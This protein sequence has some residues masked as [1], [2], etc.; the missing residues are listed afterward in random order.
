MNGI[1]VVA[2]VPQVSPTWLVEA[3][4]VNASTNKILSNTATGNGT[5]LRQWPAKSDCT[6]LGNQYQ[7]NTANKRSPSCLQ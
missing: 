7:G 5:D 6:S 3:L 4:R 1:N 2:S